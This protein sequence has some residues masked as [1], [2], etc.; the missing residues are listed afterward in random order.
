MESAGDLVALGDTH[1]ESMQFSK[2]VELY[3]S[4]LQRGVNNALAATILCKRSLAYHAMGTSASFNASLSD[5]LL[6]VQ[7]DPGLAIAYLRAGTSLRSLRQFSRAEQLLR[8]GLAIAD[9]REIFTNALEELVKMRAV[10]SEVADSATASETVA[11]AIESDR[12]Q[13]LEHWLQSGG[14]VGDCGSSNFPALYMR[15]YEDSASN[16]G[17]HCRVDM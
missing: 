16:R 3:T 7:K 11:I 8:D 14:S 2:A 6:A 9:D 4:A 5:G 1:V 17:V 13:Q 12:F 15:L 10:E